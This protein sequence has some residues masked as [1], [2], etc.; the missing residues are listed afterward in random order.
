MTDWPD[1]RI[2][3]FFGIEAPILLAP[4]A[5]PGTTALAIAV[6]Q[7]GGLGA[8]AC[9]QLSIDQTTAALKA[10]R[11]ATTG[12]VNLNFFCHRPPTPDPERERAWR[13]RLAP[14]Y[15]ELG[16]DTSATGPAAN[17]APFD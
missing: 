5:G 15:A 2:Q 13:A 1:S 9:A 10:I 7:A 8:L 4:M 16:L 11:A 12:P 6:S 3:N 17:R 14:Y